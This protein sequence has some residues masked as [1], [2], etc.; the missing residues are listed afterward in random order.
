MWVRHGFARALL[1]TRPVVELRRRALAGLAELVPSDV[2]MWDRVELATG[3]VRHEVV[4]TEAEPPGAFASVVGDAADHPLLFA[5]ASRRRAALRL[6]EAVELRRLSHSELYGDLLHPS[7][8]E[9]CIT[10]GV[11]SER[12]EMVVAGL[13]R[14]RTL[15]SPTATVTCSISCAL[16]SRRRFG[17]PTRASGSSPRV[18]PTRRRR[19]RA[20][21]PLR[22]DR[23]LEP[24]CRALVGEHFGVAEH[25]GWLPRTVAEWLP[26]P[27]RRRLSVSE[28]DGA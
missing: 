11:R 23:A 18:L 8:V 21:R 17:M 22:R 26:L 27:P 15:S 4:P 16:S 10:I 7:G 19:R 20:A 3:A 14:T 5:H 1:R 12:R 24:R 13:G 28:T 25:A 9:Y 6:S 2:L